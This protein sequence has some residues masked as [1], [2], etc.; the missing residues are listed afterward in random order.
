MG[1]SQTKTWLLHITVA[2]LLAEWLVQLL[3]TS[4]ATQPISAIWNMNVRIAGFKQTIN[5]SLEIFLLTIFCVIMDVWLL[6]LPIST[7]WTL[8]L[9][10]RTRI[11][12]TWC[13]FFGGVACVGAI[14]KCWYIY[15]VFNS[16]DSTCRSL[17]FIF[18]LYSVRESRIVWMISPA[19]FGRICLYSFLYR[20]WNWLLRRGLNRS[21]FWNHQFFNASIQSHYNHN[22]SA[23]C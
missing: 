6:L 8:K 13:F 22:N 4:F 21:K 16:Y 18:L 14:M 15:P 7:I 23:R 11:S 10:L 17:L 19:V 12:V 9:P 5:L 2:L 3:G 20:A 1:H